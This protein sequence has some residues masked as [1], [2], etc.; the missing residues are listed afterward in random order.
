MSVF[1]SKLKNI[2][3]PQMFPKIYK[4]DVLLNQIKH[5][6]VVLMVNLSLQ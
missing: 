5:I 6:I 3:L 1:C 2:V 4:N